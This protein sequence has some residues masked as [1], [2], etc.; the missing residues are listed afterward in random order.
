MMKNNI[1]NYLDEVIPNPKCELNYHT[2]YELLIATMLSAQTTDKMVNKVTSILFNKYPNIDALSKAD[3][4]DIK[5]I[6]RPLGNYNKKAL[7]IVGIATSLIGYDII[8]KDRT[9]IES[10]PGVGR[11][12]ANVFLANIYDEPV[13]AVDTHI[14]RVSKRLGIAKTNDSVRIVEDKLTKYFKGYNINRLHHQLLL[15]G[16]YHC[17]AVNPLCENC[18]LKDICKHYH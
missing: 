8:P 18:K 14:E 5:E 16:R 6:I 2:D 10:L 13:M 15:F 4:A 11:K 3:I 7:N 9:F 12:T 17:K 1:I